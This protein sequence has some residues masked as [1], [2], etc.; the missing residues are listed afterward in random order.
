MGKIYSVYDMSESL[1]IEDA[2]NFKHI[3]RVLNTNLDGMRLAP[4]AIRKI[5][6]VGRRFAVLLCKKAKIPLTLRAGEM[7][8]EQIDMITEICS[9]PESF[10][11]PNWFL[12]KRF[13]FKDGKYGQVTSTDLDSKLREDV[14]R[15]KKIRLHRGLRHWFGLKVRGQHTKSTGR[16]GAPVG[17]SGK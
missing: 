17:W 8:Q 16:H 5:R 13:D 15:M 3:I 2:D 7:S 9:K 11:F 4:F 14:E 1:Y 12:N 10:G 6:G